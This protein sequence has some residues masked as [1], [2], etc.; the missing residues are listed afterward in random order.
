MSEGELIYNV[1][2]N[3]WVK[4]WQY[5]NTS[6]E[7]ECGECEQGE[8]VDVRVCM[9]MCVDEEHLCLR[10]DINLG[11][12][13]RPL[14]PHRHPCTQPSLTH[15]LTHSLI[16]T[17]SNVCSATPKASLAGRGWHTLWRGHVDMDSLQRNEGDQKVA[18]YT[19]IL[20]HTRIYTYIYTYI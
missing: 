17:S 1:R 16:V 10:E 6:H 2:G 5:A 11:A 20:I 9:R 14:N 7:D 8:C 19:N 18:A 4:L 3:N 15:S 13:I 12:H